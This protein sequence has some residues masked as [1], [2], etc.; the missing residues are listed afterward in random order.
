MAFF[1]QNPVEL[2]F[3]FEPTLRKLKIAWKLD[4]SEHKTLK[5][6]GVYTMIPIGFHCL[7]CSLI[8]FS[9]YYEIGTIN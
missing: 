1:S 6:F 4:V 9:Q 8:M 3:S 7:S 2:G 5:I